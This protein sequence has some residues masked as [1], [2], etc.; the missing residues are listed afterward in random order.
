MLVDENILDKNLEHKKYLNSS[1]ILPAYMENQQ[2][3]FNQ[4]NMITI[5]DNN[6]RFL[7]NCNTIPGASGGP[8]ILVDDFSVIGIRY[9]TENKKNVGVLLRN[10]TLDIQNKQPLNLKKDKPLVNIDNKENNNIIIDDKDVD[11][12]DNINN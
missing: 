1:I 5:P 6:G 11:K 3:F 10:I 4:R 9:D 2:I 7:H 8:I 12:N